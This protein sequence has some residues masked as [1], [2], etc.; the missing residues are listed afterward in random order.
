[1]SRI[2]IKDVKKLTGKL[3]TQYIPKENGEFT[4]Y[5]HYLGGGSHIACNVRDIKNYLNAV[6][7]NSKSNIGKDEQPI[8][9]YKLI[10]KSDTITPVDASGAITP[11]RDISNIFAEH[12]WGKKLF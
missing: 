11:Y 1:M 4:M 6:I 5:V 9:V 2:N 12:I 7:R 3:H 8:S 10:K